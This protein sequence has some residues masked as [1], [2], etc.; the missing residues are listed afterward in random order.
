MPLDNKA[1][2]RRLYEEVWNE[3]KL[4][5]VNELISPSHALYGP[6][7]SGSAIGPEAYKRQVAVFLR[8][9]PDLRFRVEEMISENDKLVACWI[10]SGTH[11][12]EYMGIPPT[13]KSMSAEGITIHQLSNGRIMDSYACWDALGM[14]Q[15]L[16]AVAV[17][18]QPKGT[19]A[20]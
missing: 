4:E 18:G 10:I 11:Q 13:N 1:V 20:H 15:Q 16:G 19:A 3:R 12:G 5:L 2:V 7:F 17:P 6:N 9:F 8:A 14:M